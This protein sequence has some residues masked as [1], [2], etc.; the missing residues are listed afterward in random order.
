MLS[1]P[2]CAAAAVLVAGLFLTTG[3]S[4]T[5]AS[6][7]ADAG[8]DNGAFPVTIR[9]A[10]GTATV[11]EAPERV[12]TLGLGSAETAI[13]LGII[14][15][16]IE[17]SSWGADDSGYLPWIHEAVLEAGA[18]LP[19]LLSS[20]EPDLAAIDALDPDIILAPRS[21]LTLEQFEALS[22]IAP[23]VGY[24][25]LPWATDGDEQITLIGDAL[26]RSADAADLVT[27]IHDRLDL[28]ARPDYAGVSFAA[29]YTGPDTLG[30]YLPGEARVTLLSA[31]G[32][33]PEPIPSG[34]SELE[35][36]GS[37]PLGFDNTDVL[38]GADLIVPAGAAE[39]DER[40]R[41]SAEYAAIP[42]VAAGAV[43]VADDALIAAA[44]ALTPLTVPWALDRFV[45]LLDAALTHLPR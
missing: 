38:A 20:P 41:A 13:A 9:S 24:P 37:A 43:V 36:T 17:E 33:S 34:F 28:A 2:R 8:I 16:G 19:E 15:V 4:A 45:P 12:V 5:E 39:H 26:G 14:P 23:T 42:A 1:I 27:D 31:L 32:L 18:E 29:V 10:L 21:G 25:D 44:S 3:C 35:G 40:V 7:P 6:K 22:A 30:V 11:T